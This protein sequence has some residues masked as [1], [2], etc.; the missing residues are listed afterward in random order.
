MR[1]AKLRNRVRFAFFATGTGTEDYL[2]QLVDGDELRHIGLALDFFALGSPNYA[3]LVYDGDGSDSGLPGPV[4]SEAIES[5]FRGFYMERGQES[6]EAAELFDLGIAR[7]F[8]WL[9]VPAGGISGGGNQIKT[10]EQAA[11][12]G[13]VAGEQLDPCFALA[14]DTFDNVSLSALD[15]NSDAAAT[16]ILTYA[17]STES[18]NGR[19]GK[20]NFGTPN[21]PPEGRGMPGTEGVAR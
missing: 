5:L 9:G 4:G 10:P 14:C 15:V 17:M 18:V 13:G 3:N 12:Y 7:R 8:A 21:G 16:A 6:D 1:R 20:G 11:R 19:K 2:A